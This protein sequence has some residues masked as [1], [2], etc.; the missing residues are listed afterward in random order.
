MLNADV[1][2]TPSTPTWSPDGKHIAFVAIVPAKTPWNI[3]M[4]S[5]PEG[6]EWT[7]PPRI[8]SRLHYRQDRVGFQDPGFSHLFVVPAESGST[9]QL[10]DGEWHVGAQ[11]DGLFSGAGL[12]WTADSKRIVFDGYDDPAHDLAYRRSH[13]Y[14]I[15]IETGDKTLRAAI[16]EAL[17]AW[18]TDPGKS[19]V[20][21]FPDQTIDPRRLGQ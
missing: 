13:I 12:S 5:P 9:R 4:P 17:R 7:K 1:T 8:L 6:A 14:S 2:V 15:D 11:F 20:L 21:E 3:D 16:D 19:I 18:V 10:T